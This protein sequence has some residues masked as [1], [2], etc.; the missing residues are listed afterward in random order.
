MTGGRTASAAS[1]S[2]T[3]NRKVRPISFNCPVGRIYDVC[4]LARMVTWLD[5]QL[6]KEG[7]SKGMAVVQY[8][9]PI[10]AV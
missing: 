3:D 8:S 7:K 2:D 1:F 10:E 4:S 5:L 6:D 9:H